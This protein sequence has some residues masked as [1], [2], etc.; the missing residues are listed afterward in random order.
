MVLHTPST[1]HGQW[2]LIRVWG[3]ETILLSGPSHPKHRA[4]SV[5]PHLG[6]GRGDYCVIWSFTH[7]AHS[8]VNAASDRFGCENRYVVLHTP[9]T[10]H[11]QWHLTWVWGVETVMW[12][13]PAQIQC[14]LNELFTPQAQRRAPHVMALIEHYKCT[15]LLLLLLLSV[16]TL[17]KA[18]TAAVGFPTSPLTRVV[19]MSSL[20]QCITKSC[21]CSHTNMYMHEHTRASSL[22]S[23]DSHLQNDDADVFYSAHLFDELCWCLF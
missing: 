23:W 16:C 7:Q 8:T 22:H 5:T 21:T 1:E 9:S 13:P 18:V 20:R 3:V 4:W 17:G 12:S 10:Q 14:L 11:G 15:L 19:F 2:H 6:L